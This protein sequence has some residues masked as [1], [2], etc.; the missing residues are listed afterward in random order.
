MA[1]IDFERHRSSNQG[2]GIGLGLDR[3]AIFFESTQTDGAP[4][5]E[6]NSGRAV[7]AEVLAPTLGSL[8]VRDPQSA[9]GV[10]GARRVAFVA[11]PARDRRAL[12]PRSAHP[13]PHHA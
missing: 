3:A 2:A 13:I 10:I 6:R 5:I 9:R 1:A 12:A 7:G 11:R 4:L 8:F